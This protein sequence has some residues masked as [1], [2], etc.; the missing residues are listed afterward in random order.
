M[1]TAENRTTERTDERASLGIPSNR[2]D[3]EPLPRGAVRSSVRLRE[4]P[5]RRVAVD[6]PYLDLQ[7]GPII[8]GGLE[9]GTVPVEGAGV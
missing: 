4:M 8:T 3:P 1:G 6:A 9:V 2:C 7:L 5:I